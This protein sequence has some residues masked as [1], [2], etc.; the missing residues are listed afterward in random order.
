[1]GDPGVIRM[2]VD[3]ELAADDAFS[4]LLDELATALRR[5]GIEPD[6]GPGGRVSA[7]ETQIARVGSWRA[8][9]HAVL[10]WCPADWQP[11]QQLRIEIDVDATDTGSRVTLEL[12]GV[13]PL[14]GSAA[15]LLGWFSTEVAAATLSVLTPS[16]FGDWITDR[17]ARR[18]TGAQSRGIYR[19]PLFHYPNFRVI[20]EDL[21]LSPSDYLLEVGCGGGA[22]LQ[23]ALRSGCRAAGV[24][25][26]P[27]MIHVAREANRAAIENGRL[28]IVEA[29]AASL[30]FANGVFT[31]AIM[32]G[33]LGFLPDPVAGLA[34][35]HRVLAPG[36][37]IVILGSDPEMR[38]TPAAPEP[39]ASRLRFYDDAQLEQLGRAAGFTRVSVVQRDLEG[40][41]REAGVP[42]EIV[43]LFKG[44][45]RF[46]VAR[47]A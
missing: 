4:A 28:E 30:P 5:H 10:E 35:M 43:P 44:G 26:S 1:M 31:C 21:A 42:E 27:D 47:K 18:P 24:D 3:V 11:D 40:Y 41:A 16:A 39:M 46:L 15:E 14:V 22:F 9:R 13:E 45:T 2:I 34:E 36:G 7:R 19:D 29:N 12:H 8:G 37:R 25:Y 32:T 6:T 23:M 33:V 38:G 17:Q 20:L